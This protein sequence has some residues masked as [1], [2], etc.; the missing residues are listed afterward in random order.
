MKVFIVYIILINLY[1]LFIMYS[2]KHKAKL[3]KW[4]IPEKQ[5]FITAAL[6]GSLGVLLGM[7]FFRHKTKHLKF[8]LGIPLI[9]IIQI[10]IIFKL[11]IY[12]R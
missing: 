4:R 12:N 2:D 11:F 10:Y 1:G 8:T 9:L 5:I 6:F 7:N 3:R